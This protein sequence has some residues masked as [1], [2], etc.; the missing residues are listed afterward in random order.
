MEIV[1]QSGLEWLISLQ[2]AGGDTAA[3][4]FKAVTFLGD[5]EFYLLMF[6]LIFWCI[7]TRLGVRVAVAYLIST[8]I[9]V[10]IKELTM[11]PRPFDL[12]PAVGLIDE[13]G[14][15]MPSN[16]AQATTMIFGVLAHH[17][18]KPWAWAAAV[19]LA[20]LVG[21]SRIYLGLHFPTQ[22]IVGWVLGGLF[23]TV[24]I[25]FLDQIETWVI[26]RSLTQ[27]LMYA[28][29]IALVGSIMMPAPD[30]VAVL[31]VLWGLWCGL[32]LL[33]AYEVPFSADGPLWQKVGRFILGG[34]IVI[35]LFAGLKA[36]FPD[37]GESLY[38]VFRFVRYGLIGLFVGYAAPWLFTKVGL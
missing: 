24:Y 22:V 28:T 16:H 4:F 26:G 37:A 5:Q 29:A 30:I 7:D 1:L 33:H 23:L 17:L 11:A 2:Q 12:N 34:I 38:T 10:T 19:I 15:G 9:N 35:G 27:H 13:E 20:L 32:A 8:W 18:K 6:P 31:A 3:T 36:I 21:F 25:G 14:F